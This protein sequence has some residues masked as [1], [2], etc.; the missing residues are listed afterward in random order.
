MPPQPLVKSTRVATLPKNSYTHMVNTFEKLSLAKKGHFL[1]YSFHSTTST[2]T[3]VFITLWAGKCPR[4]AVWCWSWDHTE[5][6]DA[7]WGL[8]GVD[9]TQNLVQW[10]YQL[11]EQVNAC[12]SHCMV[13]KKLCISQA[14]NT[15]SEPVAIKLTHVC[16][17]I[18]FYTFCT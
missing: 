15:F 9:W 16:I 8:V 7:G 12:N 1:Q 14:G 4:R 10:N 11:W 18:A 13:W 3:R 5:G 6:T 2:V 17:L